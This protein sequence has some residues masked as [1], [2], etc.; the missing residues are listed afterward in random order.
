QS[1]N[2]DILTSEKDRWGTYLRKLIHFLAFAPALALVLL[3]CSSLYLGGELTGTEDRDSEKLFGLL[4]AAK[5]HELLMLASLGA[6]LSTHIRLELGRDGTS[7]VPAG[8]LF[9]PFQFQNLS[10]LLSSEMAGVWFCDR[11]KIRH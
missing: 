11:K 5:I 9:A 10:F 7:G 4:F 1:T 6:I 3:N 8:A 2:I